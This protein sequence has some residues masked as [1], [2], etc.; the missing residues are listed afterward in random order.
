MQTSET[1]TH[2]VSNRKYERERDM[3]HWLAVRISEMFVIFLM[4][5]EVGKPL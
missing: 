3:R 4:K 2:S 5:I 1:N